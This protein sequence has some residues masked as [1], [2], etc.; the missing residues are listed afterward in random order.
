MF[1]KVINSNL[2]AEETVQAVMCLPHKHEDLNSDAQHT[3]RTARH[4]GQQ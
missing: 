4:S 2:V 1:E 3:W